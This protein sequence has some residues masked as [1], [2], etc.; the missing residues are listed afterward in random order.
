MDHELCGLKIKKGTL[1]A[2]EVPPNNFSEHYHEKPFEFDPERWLD[3]NSRTRKN[4]ALDPHIFVPFSSGPRNCIGQH[5]ALME[6]K[7]IV[8]LFVK[9]FD[10]KLRDGYKMKLVTNFMYEP[11]EDLIYQLTARE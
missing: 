5:M 1:I 4:L 6:A 10:F 9:R 11:E 7:I 2:R 8:G 3:A